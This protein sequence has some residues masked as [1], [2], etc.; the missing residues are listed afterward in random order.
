M[1]LSMYVYIITT[2]NMPKERYYY[3]GLCF[4]NKL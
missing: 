3:I 1:I 4:N 2:K